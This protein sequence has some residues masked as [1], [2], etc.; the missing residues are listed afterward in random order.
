[1]SSVPSLPFYALTDN[2]LLE[3]LNSSDIIGN[4]SSQIGYS[5]TELKLMYFSQLSNV[6]DNYSSDSDPD[7]FLQG[8]LNLANPDCDYY[9]P[10][11]L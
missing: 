4:I 1:M 9:F 8:S 5:L 3:Q 6:Y 2:E 11:V 10:D 7:T